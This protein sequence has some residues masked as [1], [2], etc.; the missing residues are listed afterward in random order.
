MIIMSMGQKVPFTDFIFGFQEQHNYKKNRYS[1][2]NFLSAAN[3]VTHDI[4][5][6]LSGSVTKMKYC[7]P[8]PHILMS[9]SHQVPKAKW[10]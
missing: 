2:K 4:F 9:N 7:S 8:Y 1:P 5:G 6:I 10:V 3:L